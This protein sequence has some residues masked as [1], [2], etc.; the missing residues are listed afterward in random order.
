M[1][2]LVTMQGVAKTP[3]GGARLA[4]V[5][6]DLIVDPGQ[7]DAL[8]YLDA[9]D[10]ELVATAAVTANPDTGVWS[11]QLYPSA[12]IRPAGSYYR[13][14]YIVDGITLPP[15]YFLVPAGGG[16]IGDN[17]TLPPGNLPDASSS[18]RQIAYTKVA[19]SLSTSST[20]VADL[21]GAA[22]TVPVGSR[23]IYLEFHASYCTRSTASSSVVF[24]LRD[25]T[26]GADVCTWPVGNGG[27]GKPVP[28]NLR[29]PLD[30]LPAPGLRN[31]QMRWNLGEAGGSAD[32][33]GNGF[34]SA[35]TVCF[36]RAIEH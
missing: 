21:A 31:Y 3:A 10:T 19:A 20:S 24:V 27:A 30:P 34:F 17:L 33:Y 15:I 9:N 25:T 4:T 2:S 26:A 22:M 23:P 11:C 1:T 16:W 5:L 32:L 13:A 14:T 12:E 8:G 18:G 7:T 35:P 6:I 36:L 29:T 28:V